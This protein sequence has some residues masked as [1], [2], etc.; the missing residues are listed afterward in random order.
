M[1][2]STSFV[3]SEDMSLKNSKSKCILRLIKKYKLSH[4]S[5]NNGTP[6]RDAE[7]YIIYA[8]KKGGKRNHT[9]GTKSIVR[10]SFNF[11]DRKVIRDCEQHR[12]VRAT[13]RREPFRPWRS[14]LTSAERPK[15][16][17]PLADLP[18]WIAY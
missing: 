12:F 5:N 18:K 11:A 3:L 14:P 15:S 17:K 9:G 8:S 4:T 16:D 10:T 6:P 7:K 2:I 13:V 1:F